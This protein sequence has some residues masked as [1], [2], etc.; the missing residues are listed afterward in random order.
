MSSNVLQY[1]INPLH[2]L[3]Q[4]DRSGHDAESF[5]AESF[6][7]W[8]YSYERNF[9][10]ERQLCQSS[11]D[12][13]YMQTAFQQTFSSLIGEFDPADP[14]IPVMLITFVLS[15][16]IAVNPDYRAIFYAHFQGENLPSITA[17]V[18]QSLQPGLLNAKIVVSKACLSKEHRLTYEDEGLAGTV[19]DPALYGTPDGKGIVAAWFKMLNNHNHG[20]RVF[21]STIL[22]KQHLSQL[23][24]RNK[25]LIST[26]VVSPPD[27]C[28][29]YFNPYDQKETVPHEADCYIL[30]GG[31]S[32]LASDTKVWL[33][34]ATALQSRLVT[35]QT[36]I[37]VE[38]D[39]FRR[40]DLET[41]VTSFSEAT[42]L[43]E[44]GQFIQWDCHRYVLNPVSQNLINK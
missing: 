6:E 18:L 26:G 27:Y 43:A 13:N 17:F 7:S 41:H 37:P 2:V 14:F 3:Y 30:K 9:A 20:D 4:M 23:S 38:R 11:Q 39:G 25:Q 35:D 21:A 8:V 1:H 32:N 34:V 31:Q 28:E 44:I 10:Y 40:N 24:G 16:H 12:Y 15:L 36:E 33:L 22:T 19:L 29:A 42:L 5:D